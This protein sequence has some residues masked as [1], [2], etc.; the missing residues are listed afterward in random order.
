M[1]TLG[2][3]VHLAPQPRVDSSRTASLTSPALAGR[4]LWTDFGSGLDRA[5][6]E[7][8]PMLV[9]FEVDW[10][11][12]CR[13]MARTTWKH[14]GVIERLGDL[15]NVRVNAEETVERN[16]FTGQEL[17]A[18]YGVTGFPT[19]ML[20]DADGRVLNTTGGYQEPRQLLTWI[21]DSLKRPG[22]SRATAGLGVSN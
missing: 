2:W 10:C 15:V 11:G 9:N 21:E 4:V 16:G 3:G 12:Y 8:K 19:L 6:D 20:V 17:A 22:R 7:G 14:P 13:K 5:R 18:R 1:A